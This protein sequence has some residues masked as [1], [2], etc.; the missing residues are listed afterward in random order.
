MHTSVALIRSFEFAVFSQ[1]FLTQTLATNQCWI[2]L[3]PCNY[4]KHAVC[5][6]HSEIFKFAFNYSAFSVIPITSHIH[7]VASA[8]RQRRDLSVLR[9]K[10]PPAHLSTKHVG[11][12]TLSLFTAERRAR[13]L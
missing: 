1:H 9:V 5:F 12:F 10:L 8:R 6:D 7:R 11:G 2:Y 3:F 13:K 4:F